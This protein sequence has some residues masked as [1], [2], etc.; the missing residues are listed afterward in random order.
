MISEFYR[1]TVVQLSFKI[2]LLSF[3]LRLQQITQ[4]HP[5]RLYPGQSHLQHSL[6]ERSQNTA[7]SASYYTP[8]FDKK[9]FLYVF[10][11]LQIS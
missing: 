3:E 2:L 1:P 11:F 6:F 4:L 9:P 5:N 10:E 7:T 8:R